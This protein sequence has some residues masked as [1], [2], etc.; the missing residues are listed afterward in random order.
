MRWTL[1]PA[2]NEEKI[3]H[4]AKELQ[5]DKTIAKI[6]CQRNIET[7][8]EA[9]QFF[10]PS[11]ADIHDPFL[12]KDM[13]IAVARIEQAIANK[14]NILVF[15]DYDVDGASSSALLHHLQ[16][17]S[18]TLP[19]RHVSNARGARCSSPNTVRHARRVSTRPGRARAPRKARAHQIPP[20]SKRP[21]ALR[22]LPPSR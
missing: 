11:L 18:P 19:D 20:S 6:L 3:N 7:F 14:E 8:S 15:G 22:G 16:P 10:R 4:L 12:L 9:K 17:A 1:K 21:E 13:D 2:P 5:V